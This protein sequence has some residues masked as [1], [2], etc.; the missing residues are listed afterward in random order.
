[1][2]LSLKHYVYEFKSLEQGKKVLLS[3][4]SN[5]VVIINNVESSVIIKDLFLAKSFDIDSSDISGYSILQLL[6]KDGKLKIDNDTILDISFIDKINNVKFNIENVRRPFIYDKDVLINDEL[7]LKY[8]ELLA[9][10]ASIEDILG[11]QQW[12]SVRLRLLEKS[13]IELHFENYRFFY[14]PVTDKESQIAFYYLELG[15]YY[16]VTLYQEEIN[17]EIE[18]YSFSL[19]GIEHLLNYSTKENLITVN[20]LIQK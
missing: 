16:A 10:G 3:Q 2:P 13:F 11:G 18:S 14:K 5:I 15:N 20:Q 6:S 8:V 7:Q 4:N 12:E 17:K 1:M 9:P 19:N